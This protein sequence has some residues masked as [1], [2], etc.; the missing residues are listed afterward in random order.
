MSD[1]YSTDI[2]TL[3]QDLR[4]G[5]LANPSASVRRVSKLCGSEVEL[6][7]LMK[8]GIVTDFAQRVR[9]CALGQA[10]AAILGRHVVG[11]RCAEIED[12]RDALHAMLKL[13]GE[14]PDGRFAQL[15]K[16]KSVRGY[17][18]RHQSVMLAFEAATEACGLA[19]TR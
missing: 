13:D 19:G 9:A 1:I 6:D 14:G 11:A 4:D 18:A 7:L 2:I 12:A 15:R 3:A 8:D 17:P 10:A 16:L 5:S